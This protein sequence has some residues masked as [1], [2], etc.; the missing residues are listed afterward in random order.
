MMAARLLDPIEALR[1]AIE[2]LR[3]LTP[4]GS[5]GLPPRDQELLVIAATDVLRALRVTRR[6]ARALDEEAL[7]ALDMAA[8]QVGKSACVDERVEACQP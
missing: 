7:L 5:A 6:W 4:L 2:R 8:E 3:T 1:S